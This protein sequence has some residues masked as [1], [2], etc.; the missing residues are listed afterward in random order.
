MDINKVQKLNE[1]AMNLK[2]HNIVISKEDAL[3]QAERIYGNENDFSKETVEMHTNEM[4]ELRKEVRKLTI[5]MQHV[6]QDMQDM[7]QKSTQLEKELN[8]ARV[9]MSARSARGEQRA[10]S[11]EREAAEEEL[12]PK[13][14]VSRPID[15]N[16]VAPADVSVEK[17][18]YFGD[19]R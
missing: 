6:V 19:K 1:M 13:R 12:R 9:G 18:F 15:R 4:D 14:D 17:F 7:K 2:R 8:D 16:N 11:G 5:A 3:G 10:V